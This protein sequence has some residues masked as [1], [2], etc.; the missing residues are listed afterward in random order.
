MLRDSAAIALCWLL[1]TSPIYGQQVGIE[2]VR[3]KA[4]IFWRPYKPVTEPPVRLANSD[5][6]KILI[7]AGKLYLTANDAIALA[8]ENNI[9]IENAR[10]SAT[11]LGWNLERAEAGGALPGV[12]S[13]SSQTQSVQNGQGVLGSQQAAGVNI[14]GSRGGSSGTANATVSQVGPVTA[15]LDPSIQE[16]NVFVHRTNPQPNVVQSVTPVLI[17]GA[18]NFTGSYQQ[19]FLTGG[20]VTISFAEHYLNENA[21]TDVLNPSV[22]PTQAFSLQHNLLQGR[23]IAVNA[24]NITVAQ[25]NLDQSDLNFKTQVSRVVAN[26]LNVYYALV[27]DTDDVKAKQSALETAQRFYAESKQRY[28]LGALAQ[29]DVT[30]AENQVA[31]GKQAVINSDVNRRQQELQLKNLISRTGIGDPL[32]TETEIIP[33]DHLT[34]PA[35]EDLPPVKDLVRQ[36]LANRTDLIAERENVKSQEIS[37]IGTKNGLL[38][39]A[40]VFSTRTTA[41]LAGTPRLVKNRNGTVTTSDPYFV[42]GLGTALGQVFR[43]N[44]PTENIGVFG[45][46]TVYARQSQADYAIDQLSLRQQQ[47]ITARDMNQAEVDVNNVVVALRQ[48]RA[49]YEAAVQSRILQQ[50][51]YDAEEKRFSLGASTP[52]NV[53]VQQRDLATAQA[54]ELSALATYQSALISLDQTTGVILEKNHVVLAEAH[55]GKVAQTSSLPAQ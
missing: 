48:S 26:V 52:Y 49:R 22:A 9:D 51:L 2:P 31:S 33:V 38:P 10:Y 21:P 8:L 46:A 19:G 17:Q 6:M 32:L 55:S 28:E 3:P 42:G 41:G 11:L 27:A 20:S 16:S 47:L 4:S 37:D 18:R 25:R 34:T 5:R 14:A 30:S 44:Y 50:Q 29:L 23:G 39:N 24:R 43:Q 36:T 12:P 54:A 35:A 7:R 45:Q 40:Q 53:V 15:N 1:A 13:A